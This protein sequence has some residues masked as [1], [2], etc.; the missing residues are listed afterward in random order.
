MYLADQGIIFVHVPKC[1]G[2]SIEASLIAACGAGGQPR[3]ALLLGKNLKPWKGPPGLGHLR[4][5]DYVSKGHLPQSEWDR[6]FKFAFVRHPLARLVSVYNYRAPSRRARLSGVEKW[7]FRQFV[8]DYF[9][10]WFEENYLN[11]H[12]SVTHV[13]PMWH[14]LYDEAG[15]ELLVDFVGKLENL[16]PDFAKACEAGGLPAETP[17]LHQNPSSIKDPETG[18]TLPEGTKIPWRQYYDDDTLEFA[19]NHYAR[20]FEL[21]GYDKADV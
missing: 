19:L 6:C 1:A 15:S 10:K 12:D 21:F 3:E 5:R 9:P 4:A 8:L 7:T 20:D 13:R 18:E 2:T 11:G 16:K 14:M 17:L